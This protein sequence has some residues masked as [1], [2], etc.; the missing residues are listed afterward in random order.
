MTLTNDDWQIILDDNTAPIEPS[1]P[2][3]TDLTESKMIPIVFVMPIPLPNAPHH[4]AWTTTAVP[5][6]PNF[7]STLA[8]AETTT[9][10]NNSVGRRVE[11]T[12][13]PDKKLLKC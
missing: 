11:Q 1:A 9:T 4:K 13:K 7:T 10:A 2:P 5:V 6:A 3:L 12:N 8:G